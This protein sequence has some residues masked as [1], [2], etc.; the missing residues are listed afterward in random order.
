MAIFKAF[1]ARGQYGAQDGRMGWN[2]MVY[3]FDDGRTNVMCE[4]NNS[5][6]P[7][8][9]SLGQ[10]EKC[11][12]QL[13]GLTPKS[14]TRECI[15]LK[16]GRAVP[17]DGETGLG[18]PFRAEPVMKARL[19]VIWVWKPGALSAARQETMDSNDA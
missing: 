11:I 14:M 5:S 9:F 13:D 12:E 1:V 10:M 7:G 19:R 8:G 15:L 16:G 17:I 3:L 6:T 4:E 2:N 18:V